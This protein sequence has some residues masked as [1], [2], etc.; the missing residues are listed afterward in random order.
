MSADAVPANTPTTSGVKSPSARIDERL[1]ELNSLLEHW[2][3]IGAKKQ[4][5]LSPVDQ[6]FENCLVQVRLGMASSLF[7]ALRCKHAQTA[8]HSLRVAL[9]CSAWATALDVPKEEREAI[10]VAAL[11]HDVGKIGVPDRVLLKPGALAIE[12]AVLMDRYR[13][14]TIEILTACCASPLVLSLVSNSPAWFDGSKPIGNLSGEKLP[15]GSRLI[16]IMDA[17]DAMTCAQIYR[18]AF[19]HERAVKELF[20]FAGTQFDPRLVQCFSELH[21]HDL[22]HLHRRTAGKWLQDLDAASTESCWQLSNTFA[23]RTPLV[24]ETLFQQKLLDNMNDGVVFLDNNLQITLWNHGAER[25]TGIESTAIYQRPFKP[26]VF[27]LCDEHGIDISDADCP[28]AHA[29]HAG[30]QS[31]MRAQIRGRND[32]VVSVDAHI[33][34]VVAA[35]GTLHGVTL[36]LH[37]VSPETS[38]EERCQRLHEKAIRDP[39]TQVANRAEFDRVH[40]IFVDTHL[41]RGLACSLIICDIDRFK[42]VNDTYG[43]PAGD[44]VIK[45]FAQLLKSK[46]RSGD[47]VARYGGEEFVMLCADCGVAAAFERAEQIRRAFAQLPQEAAGGNPVTASFGVT[48]TQPG[49]SAQ[50]MLNRADRALLLAKESGRNMVVQLG[51]G[52]EV[53]M[54]Q[55]PWWQF[56]HSGTTDV[57]LEQYLVTLVP[58]K[59][60]IE[61]LR[62]F[63]SDHSA[64]IKSIEGSRIVMNVVGHNP[65][66]A[67]RRADRPIPLVVELAFAEEHFRANNLAPS[68]PSQTRTK[69]QVVMR[70]KRG[71][72]RRQAPAVAR[73]R[74]LLSSLRSYL[75]ATD[76]H[77][78][79]DDGVVRRSAHMLVPWLLKRE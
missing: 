37:D 32:R 16:A 7:M 61:K 30:S 49:D 6:T 69:I 68:A 25:L 78:Q 79:T 20:A 77:E 41:Q 74:Q 39:L 15:L 75:M 14:M 58:L 2:Q 4:A 36:V 54:P 63:V 10:E 28:I 52:G 45:S 23:E 5:N 38:L 13:K 40:G 35:D 21:E 11:L 29:L 44:E 26:S 65:V 72:D 48:E 33:M 51:A 18:P 46:C 24:T 42:Q 59:V 57:I 55:R 17:F 27:G 1:G 66:E 34:P 73:A 47:L 76:D 12:E 60:A 70:P 8:S 53:S 19:S 50:T 56:W 31:L 43:H 67:R 22:E 71:R 64:E 9:G 62:G 3:Q